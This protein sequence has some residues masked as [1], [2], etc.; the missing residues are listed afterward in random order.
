M[1]RRHFTQYD[2]PR[3]APDNNPAES[4]FQ[5]GML[6]PRDKIAQIDDA[7]VAFITMK[8]HAQNKEA[9]SADWVLKTVR[10]G[11]E[12][13]SPQ[14]VAQFAHRMVQGPGSSHRL[15]GQAAISGLAE[16][17][18]VAGLMSAA[19]GVGTKAMGMAKKNPAMAGAAI[20]AAGGAVAG[21]PDHRLGGAVAGAGLGA[22]A[23]HGGNKMVANRA[24]AHAAED[25]A[26]A[27]EVRK[28]NPMGGGGMARGTGM[29]APVQHQPVPQSAAGAR[30]QQ[31]FQSHVDSMMSGKAP[32]PKMQA[33]MP[34]ASPS[35][36]A[37][38]V[39]SRPAPQ[40][41]PAP[42][43]VQPSQ[44]VAAPG[45][46]G[47]S[48][49]AL[50]AARSELRAGGGQPIYGVGQ[51]PGAT[52]APTGAKSQ[53]AKTQVLPTDWSW[54]QAYQKTAF[55]SLPPFVVA[56][57][58]LNAASGGGSS[59]VKKASLSS[60]VSFLTTHAPKHRIPGLSAII[61]LIDDAAQIGRQK[62]QS[63][64]NRKS[65]ERE[66]HAS[67]YDNS[68]LFDMKQRAAD[69][70]P[71]RVSPIESIRTDFKK[72]IQF[73]SDKVHDLRSNYAQPKVAMQLVLQHQA[74]LDAHE[75]RAHREKIAAEVGLDMK[76]MARLG[77]MPKQLM[78]ARGAGAAGLGA[79]IGGGMGYLGSRSRPEL[80]GKSKAEV[81]L[82]AARDR[83]PQKPEGIGPTIGKHVT[84]IHAD[85][86]EQMRK[87]PV[88]A[89]LAGAG[90]GAGLALRVASMLGK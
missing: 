20:G 42:A 5:T 77:G 19:K 55:A 30:N 70:Y 64:F 14:R 46:G 23:A 1:G 63:E 36:G 44:T 60:D 38:T 87:H 29:S 37:P 13:A 12:K 71:E 15:A 4:A 62:I 17:A 11:A 75:F 89:T 67:P 32:P 73:I 43:A 18:K 21:G 86:A 6:S 47:Q 10:S 59:A 39:A 69:K 2:G 82:G 3:A 78:S 45:L 33:Q 65:N 35:Q 16:K 61:G 53:A 88:A 25:K 50:Q 56:D 79:I 54:Q 83:Q 31:A 58:S 80:G 85:V 72:A 51:A 24:A 27:G 28:L 22:A 8:K 68:T 84:N 49:V 74:M 90:V 40:P 9:V 57:D 34:A 81:E 26:L 48:P 7:S 76:E 66:K 41:Q 52:A